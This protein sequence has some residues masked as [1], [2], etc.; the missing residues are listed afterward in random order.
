MDEMSQRHL[1]KTNRKTTQLQLLVQVFGPSL[2][3]AAE[4]SILLLLLLLIMTTTTTTILLI[5]SV[6]TRRIDQLCLL[7]GEAA[8]VASAPINYR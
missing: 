6:C 3:D 8:A 4:T 5:G 7:W 2:E 1:K